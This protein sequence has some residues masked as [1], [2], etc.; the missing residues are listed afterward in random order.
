[1]IPC[2]SEIEF[3]LDWDIVLLFVSVLEVPKLSDCEV[4]TE[5]SCVFL[6]V[7]VSV[8]DH[9]LERLFLMSHP[10]FWLELAVKD[11]VNPSVCV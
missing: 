3:V 8:T 11:K 9:S 6:L 10:K 4:D 5:F 2:I 1:M 7:S